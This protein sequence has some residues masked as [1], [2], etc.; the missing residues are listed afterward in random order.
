MPIQVYWLYL[1]LHGR[2]YVV[3]HVNI[4]ELCVFS[5]YALFWAGCSKPGA[6]A[7]AGML[8]AGMIGITGGDIMVESV[9]QLSDSAH[10]E[11]HEE[12]ETIINNMDNDDDVLSTTSIRARQVGSASCADV[13]VEISSV[14]ST[15][16]TRA[17]KDRVQQ[18]IQR[19]LLQAHGKSSSAVILV[20]AHAKPNLPHMVVCPLLSQQSR[21]RRRTLTS[22]M[23][24]VDLL[25]MKGLVVFE[26]VDF[27]EEDS[28]EGEVVDKQLPSNK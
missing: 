25:P 19:K 22:S 8:V 28:W 9:K 26:K 16:A 10:K 27:G 7:P 11:L 23:V 3:S 24:V 14:L 15:T 6:D 17:V 18:C 2:W 4:H 5:Y 20:T 1:V 13:T 12:V 21:Y